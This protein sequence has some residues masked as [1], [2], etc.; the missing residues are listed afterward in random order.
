MSLPAEPKV[1]EVVQLIHMKQCTVTGVDTVG[2]YLVVIFNKLVGK[3][4]VYVWF[5]FNVLDMLSM[6]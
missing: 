6:V 2:V 4:S 1:V 5:S 3:L